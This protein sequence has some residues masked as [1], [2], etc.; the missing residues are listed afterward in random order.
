MKNKQATNVLV[1]HKILQEELLKHK[2]HQTNRENGHD[3]KEGYHKG[4]CAHPATV[5][6]HGGR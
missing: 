4:L 3:L 5:L 6:Q 1:T 2:R